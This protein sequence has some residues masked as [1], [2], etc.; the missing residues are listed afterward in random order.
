M[1]KKI[2]LFIKVIYIFF[3]I[4]PITLILMFYF[5][6]M[7]FNVHFLEIDACLDRSSSWN[8]ELDFCNDHIGFNIQLYILEI[9]FFSLILSGIFIIIQKIAL[10]LKNRI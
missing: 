9:L 3:W 10:K 2:K 5:F 4:N 6:T 8:Y 1:N 7:G